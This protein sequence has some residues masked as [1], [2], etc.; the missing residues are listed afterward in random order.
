MSNEND[1]P[2]KVIVVSP[3]MAKLITNLKQLNSLLRTTEG[4]I[5]TSLEVF[6]SLPKVIELLEN[7]EPFNPD[8]HP[9]SGQGKWRDTAVMMSNN[10]DFYRDIVKQVGEILGKEAYTS[11]DGSVQDSVLALKV[12]ELVKTLKEKVDQ[13]SQFNGRS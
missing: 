1:I 10:A 13:Q 7:G 11:D 3:E 6:E 2:V 9:E 12:P 5:R 8:P 4:P